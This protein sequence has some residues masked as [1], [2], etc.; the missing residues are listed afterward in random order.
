MILNVVPG[1]DCK[2]V[3]MKTPI[4]K[5]VEYSTWYSMKRRC[6]D[7]KCH[8]FKYYGARGIKIC[9][10]WLDPASGF[11]NFLTDM[12][13]RPGGSYS[14]ERIDVNGDYTPENC[15]W[16]TMQEQAYN[17]TNTLVV[18]VGETFNGLTILEEV[19]PSYKKGGNRRMV[20]VLC[21]C[22]N[23]KVARLDNVIYAVAKSCG[24]PDCN[25]YAH[26]SRFSTCS[27]SEKS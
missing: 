20:K 21:K 3:S 1:I 19:N 16:I 14:I 17:K 25:K 6:Y 23:I 24:H 8:R 12:G 5:T 9:D 26:K 18:P 22:G 11:Q 2:S 10:R 15:K 7:S 4:S 27:L 13:Y